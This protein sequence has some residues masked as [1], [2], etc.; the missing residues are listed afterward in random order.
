MASRQASAGLSRQ[1]QFSGRA[2]PTDEEALLRA[3]LCWR[4]DRLPILQ[5]ADLTGSESL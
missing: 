4:S 5:I 1:K 2:C 3:L